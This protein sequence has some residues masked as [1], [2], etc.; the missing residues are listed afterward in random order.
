[1]PAQKSD[2][3]SLNASN[4]LLKSETFVTPSIPVVTT[5]F[6]PGEHE[7]RCCSGG[8]CLPS[9]G[10]PVRPRLERSSPCGGRYA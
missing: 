2:N 4:F 5:E 3:H 8:K 1:M 7:R 10:Q 6:A 9:C